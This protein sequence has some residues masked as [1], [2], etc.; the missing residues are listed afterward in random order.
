MLNIEDYIKYFSLTF[1]S[2]R[3]LMPWGI[4]SDLPE[5]IKSLIANLDDSYTIKDDIAIH[6]NV[7]IEENVVIKPPAIIREHCFI[8]ANAY[9][10][11]GVFLDKS[12]RIGPGC[13]IKQS[14]IFSGSVM[15][16]FNFIGNSIIGHDVNF[17]AG[18]VIAN[19]YNELDEKTISVFYKSEIVPTGVEKFGALVGDNSKIGANAVLSPGTLLNPNSI[20]KRLELVDQS[21]R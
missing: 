18:A 15:A 14:A 6:K 1:A 4:T 3:H 12:V 16:H 11:G 21:T 9:L 7:T 19:H 20:V 5:I 17:E 13:E 2:D 8:A 10:R